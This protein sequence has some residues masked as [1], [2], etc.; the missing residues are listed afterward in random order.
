MMRQLLWKKFNFHYRDNIYV[1]NK[2]TFPETLA[3]Q[4]QIDSVE[5][6]Y[7]INIFLYSIIEKYRSRTRDNY[8]GGFN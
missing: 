4:F 3:N 7:I 2:Q 8:N 5:I 1:Y 6:V